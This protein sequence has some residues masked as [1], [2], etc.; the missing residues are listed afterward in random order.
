MSARFFR[1]EGWNAVPHQQADPSLAGWF[2]WLA[3]LEGSQLEFC[4]WSL[5]VFSLTPPTIQRCD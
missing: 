1:R 3:A 4:G 2:S 5:H